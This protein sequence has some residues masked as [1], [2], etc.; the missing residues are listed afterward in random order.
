MYKR[1]GTI[2]KTMI[3]QSEQVPMLSRCLL[4]VVKATNYT[5][6]DNLILSKAGLQKRFSTE[7]RVGSIIKF[8][9]GGLNNLARGCYGV[10]KDK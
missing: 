4:Q 7:V 10:A 8:G 5:E 3:R 9:R 1:C 6:G 2:I